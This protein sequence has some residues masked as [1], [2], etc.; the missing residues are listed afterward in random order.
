MN[1]YIGMDQRNAL[2]SK[3]VGLNQLGKAQKSKNNRYE[4]RSPHDLLNNQS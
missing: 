4:S 3:I 1:D 2:S